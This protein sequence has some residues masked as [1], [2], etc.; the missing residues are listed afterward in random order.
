MALEGIITTV[1]NFGF[2]L[3]L[4]VYLL[5]R[6]EKKIESLTEA[7]NHLKTVIKK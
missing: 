2:P 5:L 7:I 4:A 1:G 6:F 3:V